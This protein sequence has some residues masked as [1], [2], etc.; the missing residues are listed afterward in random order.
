[1]RRQARAARCGRCA[2]CGC[3]RCR[4]ARSTR[5]RATPSSRCRTS[6]G[7]CPRCS[8]T[9]CTVS[10]LPAC[11]ATSSTS[12]SPGRSCLRR[13]LASAR[14]RACL[15]MCRMRVRACPRV[16]VMVCRPRLANMPAPTRVPG[17]IVSALGL[18]RFTPA[19]LAANLHLVL[20]K[21]WKGVAL[22]QG[23]AGGGG[24]GLPPKSWVVDFWRFMTGEHAH[25]AHSLPLMCLHVYMYVMYT[26]THVQIIHI[27]IMYIHTYC[28]YT[29]T[30]SLTHTCIYVGGRR[31]RASG[32]SV[33]RDWSGVGDVG[34]RRGGRARRGARARAAA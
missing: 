8:R 25:L 17:P 34:G 2:G 15:C 21:H 19:V 28:M 7:W 18:R 20:P 11:P 5:S 22:V 32:A 10:A 33:A 27:D 23:Y 4:A 1:M 9:W 14:A 13:R 26:C 3:C 16:R 30:H 31:A 24:A 6:S 12:T 29:L